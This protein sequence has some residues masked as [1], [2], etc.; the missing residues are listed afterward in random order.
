MVFPHENIR[1][2]IWW[3]LQVF[4][5]FRISTVITVREKSEL[6]F[7]PDTYIIGFDD[8]P[9]VFL[10]SDSPIHAHED[11]GDEIIGNIG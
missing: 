7:V 8:W 10:P 3:K 1:I 5:P 2:L 4:F 9:I 11:E 6:P